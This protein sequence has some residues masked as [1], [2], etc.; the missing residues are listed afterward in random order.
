MF[1]AMARPL[2]AVAL[3][4]AACTAPPEAT[5]QTRAP[6]RA[7]TNAIELVL[8]N[9]SAQTT[10]FTGN[11]FSL[12]GATSMFLVLDVT[13]ASGTSPTL[14]VKVQ[15]T[16]DGTSWCDFAAFGQATAVSRQ[17]VRV[18]TIVVPN[19][20]QVTCTD[21][22]LAAATVHQGPLGRSIRIKHLAPGGTTPSFTYTVKVWVTD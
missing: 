1:G 19:T 17:I 22:T 5:P 7:A 3:V 10:A 8:A 4:L 16:E 6:A 21:A 14:D 2:L 20:A 15:T 9:N 12:G 13:A 18:V 11:A